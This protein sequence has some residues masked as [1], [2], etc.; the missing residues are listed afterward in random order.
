MFSDCN[1]LLRYCE[2]ECVEIINFKIV[3]RA[4]R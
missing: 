3:D 2:S 1:D 4:G